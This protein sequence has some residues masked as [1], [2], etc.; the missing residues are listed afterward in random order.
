MKKKRKHW[1]IGQRAQWVDVHRWHDWSFI[2]RVWWVV[3][4]YL[5]NPGGK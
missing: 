5:W 1:P 2:H 3:I 4:G